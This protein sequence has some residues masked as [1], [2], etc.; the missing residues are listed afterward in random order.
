M[1][2]QQQQEQQHQP[3]H[4]HHPNGQYHNNKIDN[5]NN[6]NGKGNN[7]IINN[8][9]NKNNIKNNNTI[10]LDKNTNDQESLPREEEQDQQQPRGWLGGGE[11]VVVG[12][13]CRRPRLG[14]GFGRDVRNERK[15]MSKVVWKSH[16]FG[17]I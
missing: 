14:L 5:I 7:N 2:Q 3:Q 8:N 13:V 4:Y 12:R 11:M 10:K 9:N 17:L 15:K 16:T 6:K 1:P